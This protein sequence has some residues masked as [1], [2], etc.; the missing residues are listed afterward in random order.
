LV[1]LGILAPEDRDRFSPGD[2][3][4]VLMARSLEDA[5]IPFDGVAAA[6]QRGALSLAFLDAASYERLAA[7]S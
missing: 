4:R 5:E 1:D 3:R 2:V 6:V 7:C